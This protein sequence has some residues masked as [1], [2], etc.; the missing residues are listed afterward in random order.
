MCTLPQ[1]TEKKQ[2]STEWYVIE[3]NNEGFTEHSGPFATQ[4][5]AVAAMPKDVLIGLADAWKS[6]WIG[7]KRGKE[8]DETP[9]CNSEVS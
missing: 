1:N 7:E 2:T 5:L 4:E 8:Q 6:Y 9:P 3:R